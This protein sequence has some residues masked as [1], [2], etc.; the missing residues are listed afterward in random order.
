MPVG[1]IN[2]QITIP[3]ISPNE[4]AFDS[5]LDSQLIKQRTVQMAHFVLL[6]LHEYVLGQV[7]PWITI[8]RISPNKSAFDSELDRQFIK[9]RTVQMAHFAVF[10][11]SY[12]NMLHLPVLYDLNLLWLL[13]HY[14]QFYC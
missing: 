3:R 12:T 14:Q 2:P 6:S 5:E 10:S 9:K 13:L 11:F 4:S 1:R 7:E 8:P